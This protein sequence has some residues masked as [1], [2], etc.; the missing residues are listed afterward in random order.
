MRC[1]SLNRRQRANE[2]VGVD[3]RSARGS[4]AIARAADAYPT[5][6][7]CGSLRR[8]RIG[9]GA[10]SAAFP[11]PGRRGSA[12]A[13]CGRDKFLVWRA[14]TCAAGGRPF[15]NGLR[16]LLRAAAL[17]LCTSQ[18]S[19]LPYFIIFSSFASL[20]TWFATIR[21]RVEQDL[22]QTRDKLRLEVEE[23]SSLLDLTH[24]SI[25][26]RDMDCD[27]HLLESRR[28]RILRMDTEG[29]DWQAIR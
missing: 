1:S 19:E 29:S 10:T 2:T 20:V 9:G 5:V 7:A 4:S 3:A 11:F 18:P 25:F 6:R 13:F 24:D 8:C 22:L 15:L 21:R 23:R 27:H 14:R 17:Q 28:G 12:A 16:L 26:V